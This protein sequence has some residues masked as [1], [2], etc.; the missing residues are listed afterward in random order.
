MRRILESVVASV[1]GGFILWTLTSYLSRSASTAER[2]AVAPA[3]A[4]VPAVVSASSSPTLSAPN[5]PPA[6]SGAVSLSIP[7]VPLEPTVAAPPADTQPPRLSISAQLPEPLVT[8]RPVAKVPL[9]YSVPVGTI[10]LYEN[11]TKFR[12]GETADWGPNTFIKAGLDQRNWIVSN[13]DGVHPI[14]CRMRLPREFYWECRYSADLP[15]VTC[16]LMGWWK[17]PVASNISFQDERGNK[18]VVKWTIRC[19]NDLLRPN[20]LGSSTLYAKKYYHS[21]KL[22]DGSANEIGIAQPTGV[23]R[24]EWEQHVV[25]V[26]IDRQAVVAGAS[27][28]AGQLVGF[29]IEVV[30][31]NSGSL[32]FTD[33]RIGR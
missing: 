9:P 27:G 29:G 15:E 10:L 30:K 26:F 6:S 12:E 16:G 3:S 14:G 18:F 32:F 28:G 23:L 5:D 1:L 4:I 13:V 2:M 33:F 17:E 21:I 11:F 20:P 19:G 8:A 25:K 7:A 31:A 24:I 22:P